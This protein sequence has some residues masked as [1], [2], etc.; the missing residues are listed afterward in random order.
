ME[1]KNKF[2]VK[3]IVYIAVFSILIAICSWIS[4]P[5]TI[6]FTLQTFAIFLTIYLLGG[7]Y[8]TISIIVYLLLGIIGVPV[9]SNFG[10]GLGVIFGPTGG[11]LIGFIF[12]SLIMWLDEALF[13]NKFIF[14]IVASII[15]LIICYAFGTFWFQY[16][17]L[18]GDETFLAALSIC[19]LPYIIPDIIKIAIALLLDE[20]LKKVLGLKNIELV[21]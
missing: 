9:F 18:K 1:K 13:K 4:I 5:S 11:Y 6:P 14:K 2:G 21:E 17:Y 15:G 3:N 19:V 20:R 8:A 16:I 7:R 10:S 12:I